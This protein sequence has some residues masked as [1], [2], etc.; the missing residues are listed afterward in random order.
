MSSVK[1]T[2]AILLALALF[3]VAPVPAYANDDDSDDDDFVASGTFS[4]VDLGPPTF[5]TDGGFVVVRRTNTV[6]FEGTLTGT[7]VCAATSRV[8]AALLPALQGTLRCRGTFTGS[9][10]GQSGTLR[11]ALKGRLSGTVASPVVHA[12][13]EAERGTGGLRRLEV[14]GTLQQNGPSGTYSGEIEDD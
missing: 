4:I 14:E 2:W 1:A 13:W 12:T 10:G 6:H 9:V 5:D 7:V 3:I 11:F 8:R